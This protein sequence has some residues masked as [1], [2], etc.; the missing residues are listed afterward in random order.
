MR[1]NSFFLISTVIAILLC[2]SSCEHRPLVDLNDKRYVRIYLDE[3]LRN[4]NFG[5]YDETRERPEY[6]TPEIMRVAIFHPETGELVTERYLRDKGS[7]EKGN[8]MH[9]YIYVPK[10]TYNLMS[11]NFD[12]HAI[13]VRDDRWYSYME[14]YTAPISEQ[15]KNKL[16][17]LKTK[18]EVIVNEDILKEPEHFFVNNSKG[19]KVN[20]SET[21]DTLKNADGGDFVAKSIVKTYYMQLNIKG[22]RYVKSAAALITGMAGSVRLHDGW[23]NEDPVSIYFPMKNDVSKMRGYDETAVA[24]ATF[25]TFGKLPNVEGY[26]NITFEFNTTWG[27]VHTESIKITD[28]F[29][30]PQV[31][32]KQWIIIDKVIEITPPDDGE[33]AGG[34][35]PGVG[36]WDQVEGGI[37]I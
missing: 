34:M 23:Q 20:L 12:T 2:I 1:K 30:T 8:Y 35:S 4:V 37:T 28:M 9:G 26:I 31:K 29:E 25:N 24:Y 3:H 33:S 21:T 10:G 5:F 17:S 27:T 18:G 36:K 32:D 19:V 16:E 7:D 15:T 14:A 11:Y 6:T 13:T 22:I